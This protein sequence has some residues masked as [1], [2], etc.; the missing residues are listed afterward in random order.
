MLG[1]DAEYTRLPYFYSDQY[2]TSMEYTGFVAPDGGHDV[3][4]SGDVDAGA[5]AAFWVRDG[6]VDAG[7]TLNVPD[8]TSDIDAIVTAAVAP[9]DLTEF[10]GRRGQSATP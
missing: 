9:A 5:F 1:S 2:D 10:A 4:V 8:A 3:V 7:L 6:R